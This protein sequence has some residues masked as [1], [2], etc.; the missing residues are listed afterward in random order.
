VV[1][2]SPRGLT[3]GLSARWTATVVPRVR[4]RPDDGKLVG[5]RARRGRCSQIRFRALPWRSANCRDPPGPRASRRTVVL[6]QAAAQLDHDHPPR[7]SCWPAVIPPR[8]WP[9][10]GSADPFNSPE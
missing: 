7:P 6:S 2:S 4:H 5:P 9:P 1:R 8:S 10:A 3:A